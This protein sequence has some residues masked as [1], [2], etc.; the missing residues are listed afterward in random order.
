MEGVIVSAARGGV[1]RLR[2]RSA[3]ACGKIHGRPR[4]GGVTGSSIVGGVR[5]ERLCS[6]G[7]DGMHCPRG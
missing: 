1:V 2:G 4:V 6:K 5:G 7:S 3:R